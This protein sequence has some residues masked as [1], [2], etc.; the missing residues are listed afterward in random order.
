MGFKKFGVDPGVNF[1]LFL[2]PIHF[3]F[4]VAA[5]WVYICNIEIYKKK[6]L[7]MFKNNI[8]TYKKGGQA[9]NGLSFLKTS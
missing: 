1:K 5:V 3:P 7:T 4:V 2:V 9:L 6:M 8:Y